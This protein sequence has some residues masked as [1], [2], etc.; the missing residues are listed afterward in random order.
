M[1]EIERDL[2]Q[3]VA[4]LPF[5]DRLE[6]A[7]PSDWSERAVYQRLGDLRCS[8]LVEDLPHASELIR[9]T[10]RFLI[11][12]DGI[13][14]LALNL[15]T[16]RE[17]VLRDYPVSERW[18]QTLLRRL[19]S[20]GVIYRL[21]SA[22]AGVER[23]LRL[24]WYRAQ[25]PDAAFALP[26]GRS[27]AVLRWGRTA[28]RTAVSIRVR[29]LREGPT[30]SGVLVLVPD[31]VRLRHARRLLRQAPLI[32][33]I[34]L[35]RDAAYAS[36]D[37]RI[38][39]AP[40][41]S[42]AL[43]LEEAFTFLDA[44]G[45]WAVER[46]PVRSIVPRPLA[47]AAGTREP[48]WLLLARLKPAEKRSLDLVGDW[49]WVRAD[50]LA[51]LLGVERRRV[52]QLTAGLERHDLLT[53]HRID[54][55]RR[56]VLSDRGLALLARRDRAS[57]ASARKRWSAEPL[58][59]EQPLDW[60]NLRGGR[61]RQLLRHLV[62]TEAVHG[63]LAVLADQARSNGSELAQIE[64][65][66]RASC[67][68]RFQDRL[69]S[70]QPDAFGV[71][72]CDRRDQ[73]FF[74][75][76]ERRAIRP[77]TMAAKLAPYLRYYSSKRPL[78]DHGAPPLVLVAFDDPLAADHFLRVARE[79]QLR[80]GVPLPLRVSD[81]TAL[82]QRGPLGSAWRTADRTATGSVFG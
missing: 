48:D 23:P 9:P 61:T 62:H 38:W 52:S 51:A 46:P 1:R 40:S 78:E 27:L 69:R 33:L 41:G 72:R 26:D 29:R 34:A 57:V 75:E 71:L 68:F 82:S 76:W 60:R 16:S 45:E 66:H 7:A 5:A 6:L 18:R 44:E 59:P 70:V 43:C 42:A 15:G 32:C 64:P 19:D 81:R 36:A 10:R 65:P 31:E 77:S 22:L 74:L 12:A 49:P 4:E 63:L 50:H 11:T 73:P 21:G 80:T 28:D 17:A 8:G 20:V 53:D 54:G 39:R 24:R 2:L 13:A 67:Y 14:R 58:D 30:Y 3:L 79:E 37:A 56:F 25:P 35:E 47:A 55:Q